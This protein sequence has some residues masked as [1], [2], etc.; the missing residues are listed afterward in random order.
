MTT[1]VLARRTSSFWVWRTTTLTGLLCSTPSKWVMIR[2]RCISFS[3]DRD[4][5]LSYATVCFH[6]YTAWFEWNGI[7]G[8]WDTSKENEVRAFIFCFNEHI[9]KVNF[10]P[11]YNG[12]RERLAGRQAGGQDDDDDGDDDDDD[13]DGAVCVCYFHVCQMARSSRASCAA[14]QSPLSLC[15]L[16]PQL[17]CQRHEED[18]VPAQVPGHCPGRVHIIC[19]LVWVVGWPLAL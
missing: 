10:W 8:P 7:R 2:Y 18:E 17:Q 11:E 16:C 14:T 13:D 3:G 1:C 4:R 12:G 15:L 5:E 19:V 6:N 9:I